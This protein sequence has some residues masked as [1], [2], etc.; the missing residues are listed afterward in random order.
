MSD[1]VIVGVDGSARSL[2]AVVVAAR[3]A[4]LRAVPLRIV[5]ALGRHTM[6]PPSTATAHDSTDHG[7]AAPTLALMA[8]A[9]ERAQTTAPGIELFRLVLPGEP[10]QVLENESRHAALTVLANRGH[11]RI[12]DLL[13]GSTAVHLASHSHCPLMVVRG[14]SDP[15][16]PVLLAVNGTPTEQT[17]VEFAFAEAALR[18]APLR[19]MHV[20]NTWS[21]RAYEGPG[22][23]LNAMVTDIEHLRAAEGELLE[24]TVAPLRRT[25]P[26]VAVEHRLVRSRTR[27]AL[28][29][30]SQD[31]Q[32][33]VVDPGPHGTRTGLLLGSVS[34]TLLHHAHCPVAVIRGRR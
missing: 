9:E 16:G 19:A 1:P 15:A 30:A 8:D 20:W 7:S 28:I 3:E 31:A 10:R 25:F 26:H 22:D 34:Q 32:L 27:P 6:H 4:Q 24:R 2:E 21:E 29:D 14:R 23:P 18:E 13:L 17:A 11:S 12:A 33:V 5:H